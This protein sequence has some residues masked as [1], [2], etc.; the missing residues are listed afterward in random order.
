MRM[1]DGHAHVF[2]TLK[3]FGAEG[4]LRSIGQGRARWATGREIEMIPSEL[5][6]F[7]FT[8]E[9]L[10][11]FLKSKGVEGAVLLQGSFYGFQ[12]E[13]TY[14]VVKK[15]PDFFIGAG[16]FDPFARCADKIYERITQGFGMKAVKFET[17]TGGG[18]MGYHD[19][20]DI[21]K[22]FYE[23]V[24]KIAINNQTLVLDIGGPGMSSFQPE[25]VRRLAEEFADVHIVICHLLAPTLKDEKEL[26]E[27][28]EIVRMPNIWFDLSAVPWN[29][30]PEKYP[31]PTGLKYI[32]HGKEIVGADKLIWG[33][34]S[35]SPLTR[36]TYEHLTSYI[37]DAQIFT[38]DELDKVFYQNCKDAYNWR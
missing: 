28:L 2:E 12:N 3:G 13:Y 23:Y 21:R 33:V 30:Y 10:Y 1:M 18:L 24:K 15:Y 25:N 7:S 17:S 32:M 5:G 27:A 29:V 22:R 38:D 20:Y 6:D 11:S 37:T 19:D 16:T 14:E 9:T 8:G 4:E 36:D 34:D 26:V 35:P 31:Y